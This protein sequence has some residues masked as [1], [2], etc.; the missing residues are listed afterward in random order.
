MKSHAFLYC[1]DQNLVLALPHCLFHSSTA[2]DYKVSDTFIGRDRPKLYQA[3]LT[4]AE[5]L[6]SSRQNEI[7]LR[8]PADMRQGTAG[9]TTCSL[10]G[11][12]NP[13]ELRE[14][15]ACSGELPQ[16]Q[17][18]WSQPAFERAI[19]ASCLASGHADTAPGVGRKRPWYHGGWGWCLASV[20]TVAAVLFRPDRTFQAFRLRGGFAPPAA[21]VTVV[22]GS[23]LFVHVILRPQFFLVGL[24]N[25]WQ[26]PMF[27]FAPVVY[28]YVRAQVVHLGLLFMGR[29]KES[30]EVTFRVIAY[31]SAS[32]ALLFLLPGAGEFLFLA[33]GVWIESTGLRR[34]H[35]ISLQEALLA[36]VIPAVVLI[37]TVLAVV[38]MRVLLWSQVSV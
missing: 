34:C 10:C 37:L 35:S 7:M 26:I 19:L 12:D 8:S 25:W 2:W 20:E 13:A 32:A 3:V 9:Y 22:A 5:A 1:D 17:Q 24:L 11:A 16:C 36:E 6:K 23:A 27:F 33:T 31:G 15:Y 18:S 21:F 28:V 38:T 14:C 30:F 4:F 29:A